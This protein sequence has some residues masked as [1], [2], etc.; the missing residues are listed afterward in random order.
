[1]CR[2]FALTS[3]DPVSPMLAIDALNVMKEGHDGSGVGLYLSGLGGPFED[4]KEYPVLSGIFTDAGLRRLSEYMTEKGFSSKYSVMFK[5]DTEPPVGTPKRGTYAS[6]AYELPPEWKDLDKDDLGERLVKTRLELRAEGE[7]TGDIMVFSFWPDTIMIKEVGDP[8]AIGEYLQLGRE[9]IH[10]RHIL[11]QG[12]QNTNYAINLYACHPFFIEGIGTMTNGENTAFIPIKEYLQSRG[13]TGYQGYQS[14]SEVFTHIAHFT[15]KKLGLDISAYKHVITP[16]NDDE[17]KDHQDRE[18]LSSLK[19]AC[20]KLII[21]G[22]NCVI[23]CLENGTMFMAQDRKK[24]R[25]GVVGGNPE[26]GMYAFSSEIC[27]LNAAIPD[28]D[29]SQDFQPMHLDTA[30]VGPDC[31]EVVKCS[32]KDPLLLQR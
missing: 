14:D 21:D 17:M 24:L 16:M 5:P 11:A 26:L 7:Q 10:A 28:R 27:G 8:M 18:F 30:I 29:K 2:L 12:R 20:R 3:R 6:I 19:K 15:T 9:E 4:L 23:G 25:P 32:Q 31:R 13:V 1:M 22:P